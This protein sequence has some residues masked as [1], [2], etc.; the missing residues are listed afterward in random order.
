MFQT[1]VANGNATVTADDIA[2]DMT[3][4][5]TEF[6]VL[7]SKINQKYTKKKTKNQSWRSLGGALGALGSQD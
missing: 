5:N 6:Y 7:P 1:L 4:V 2:L 3:A